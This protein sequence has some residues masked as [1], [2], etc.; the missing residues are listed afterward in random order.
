MAN[1]AKTVFEVV[2]GALGGLA[3]FLFGGLDGLF[4]ALIAI[5]VLDYV[6][7]V[8]S[9]VV[10]KQLSSEIGFR[11]IA[12]KAFV[13]VIVSIAHMI[14]VQVIGNNDIL[15]SAVICFFI[16]NES[17]SILENAGSMGLPIPEKLKTILKQLRKEGSQNE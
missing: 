10:R 2:C 15:R 6:T 9:A 7:G 8:L 3:G 1:N 17:L 13:F 11:G 16:A 5:A 4:Y 14:D 12:K